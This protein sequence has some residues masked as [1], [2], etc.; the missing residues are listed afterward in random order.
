MAKTRAPRVGSRAWEEDIGNSPT[1]IKNMIADFTKRAARGDA[2]AAESHE[3]WLSRHPEYRPVVPRMRDLMEKVEGI[4]I[5]TV[6]G[7]DKAAEQGTTDE[8]AKVKAELLGSVEGGVGILE[9]LLASSIAVNFLV[10]QHAAA[11]L[12]DKTEHLALGTYRE[13]RM[14][15]AQKR[16]HA[17]MKMWE[18]LKEKKANG[19]RPPA[20]IGFFA[21]ETENQTAAPKAEIEESPNRP[22]PDPPRISVSKSRSENKRRQEEVRK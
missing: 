20:T 9:E 15:A 7:T 5:R 18:L 19:M 3:H 10:Q 8:V 11:R 13:H 17:S 21:E 22:S 4:W 12:A 1:F 6:S 2:D 14:T 16:L